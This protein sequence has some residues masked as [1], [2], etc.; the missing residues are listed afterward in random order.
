MRRFLAGLLIGIA[1]MYWYAY[2]K[3]A[4]VAEV[5][6]WLAYAAHDPDAREKTEKVFSRK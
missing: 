3:D 5:K 1:S 2:Q 4:F 6:E